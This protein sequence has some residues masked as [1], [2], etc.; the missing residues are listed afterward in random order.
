VAVRAE[1]CRATQ[2]RG[3]QSPE[4]LDLRMA[5]L[6][7]KTAELRALVDVLGQ[8]P[9]T[10]IVD[11]SV[12]AAL[13]VAQPK[14]CADVQALTAAVPQ[15]DDPAARIAIALARNKLAR[16]EALAKTGKYKEGHEL[17]KEA[18]AEAEGVGW[19]PLLAEAVTQLAL[20]ESR[21]GQV[22]ESE[23]SWRR[24]IQ[25]AADAKNDVLL[26]RGWA[27][28]LH[29]VGY[30]QQRH[31]EAAVLEQVVVIAAKRA[32][33]P[34]E[35]MS[36][37][38]N[39]IGAVRYSRGDYA[40]AMEIFE[41]VKDARVEAFGHENPGVASALSNMS[42]AASDL[43]DYPRALALIQEALAIRQRV[44]GPDHPQ[45]ALSLHAIGVIYAQ[46]RRDDEALAAFHKALAIREKVFGADA[47]PTAD[48]M[49]SIGI[50]LEGQSKYDEAL[51]LQ[52]KVLKVREKVYGFDHPGVTNS[53]NNI[54]SIYDGKEDHPKAREL[55][56]RVVAIREKAL[57]ADHPEVASALN[58]LSLTVK[59]QGDFDGSRKL[60]ERVLDI[61]IKRLGPDH[62]DVANAMNNIAFLELQRERY[63]EAD[64]WYRKAIP[65]FEK[66]LGQDHP[67]LFDTLIYFAETEAQRKN[68]AEAI[69]AWQR[70]LDGYTKHH[71][72]KL[73]AH[74]RA[75]I[76]K[77][78]AKARS[79]LKKQNK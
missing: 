76:E 48:T 29:T 19:S 77:A 3:E 16:V 66:K 17:A 78:I 14:G 21:I 59:K 49:S 54:A 63:D 40:G 52:E 62:P 25:L 69:D 45:T 6:D 11:N 18:L 31:D 5:C 20:M 56:E 50:V 61:R 42:N 71:P 60:M 12:E 26:A 9:D 75:E 68:F 15:P 1:A 64:R 44:L 70:A 79:D 51:V 74:D 22:Q 67:R 55:R 39:A 58:N 4:L 36:E 43:G 27:F 53:L 10:T 13:S 57:G 46:L 72:D 30:A 35:L 28:L 47:L 23:A 8:K 41:K 33:E 38:N 37:V 7:R 65:I 32:G 73:S 2:V 34:V 24:V